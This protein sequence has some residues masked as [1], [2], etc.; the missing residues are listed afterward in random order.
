MGVI[1]W[2]INRD[3][4]ILYY[5]GCVGGGFLNEQAESYQEIFY[6]LGINVISLPRSNI[7]CGITL[8]N[9]GYKKD[10][11]KLALKNFNLFKEMKII[12]IIT[13]SPECYY[14]FDKIYPEL[15]RDF[16]IEIEHVSVSILNALKSRGIRFMGGDEE[17]E[18]VSFHDSSYLGRRSLIYEEPREVIELLG[19]KIIEM[20]LNR[21]NSFSCGAGGGVLINYPD[22]AR[23]AAKIVSGR[24]PS[25]AK[26]LI[27]TSSLCYLN[28]E[29][30]DERTT[31]FSN[32][33]LNKLKEIL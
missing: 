10:A 3:K 14:M 20:K 13:N 12:K 25:Q 22:I 31:E 26:K 5:P 29:S 15:I 32:F 17:R 28:L 21:G 7:C 11:R 18:I 23:G 1:D 27:C 2:M 33:V 24:V 4:K 9:S 19:G 30:V 16:D 6:K 8:F